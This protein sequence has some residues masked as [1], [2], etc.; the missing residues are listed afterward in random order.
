MPLAVAVLIL[1]ASQ[2]VAGTLKNQPT[3]PIEPNNVQELHE[4]RALQQDAFRFAWIPISKELAVMPWGDEIQVFDPRLLKPVRKLAAG[5][6]L[7]HFAF[8]RDGERLAWSE[9]QSSVTIENLRTGRS[10]TLDTGNNQP[11]QD[12][13]PNGKWL[14]TGGYGDKASLWEVA[15]GNKIRDFTSDA[16][17]ALTPVFSPD[18]KI[19]ELGNRN[20]SS[21]LFEASTGKLLHV[22]PKRM[23]QEIR[24]SPTGTVLATTYVDGTLGLWDVAS[25][26]SLQEVKA[27]AEELYTVDWSPRG[28]L[29]SRPDC[30]RCVLTRR[31]D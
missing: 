12:F 19:M 23:T 30:R 3:I 31:V 26:K 18:G 24:F 5:K 22:L 10:T 11:S 14:V 28:D 7:V 27:T 8:S 4:L 21:R 16:K 25:G 9:N 17:G 29:A 6:Q 20:S 13:S 2:L 1:S 15:T